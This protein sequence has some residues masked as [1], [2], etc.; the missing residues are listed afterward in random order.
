MNRE[1]IIGL[2]KHRIFGWIAKA[3]LVEK[4]NKEFFTVVENV[5]GKN[6][7]STINEYSET[8]Q[9]LIKITDQYTDSEITK[10]FSKKKQ[11]TRDFISKFSDEDLK[12][13][14]REY[15]EKRLIKLFDVLKDSNISLFFNS[16]S[17]NIYNEDK[18]AIQS[19]F[20]ETV[21]NFSKEEEES[22]YFLTVKHGQSEI[23]LYNKAGHIIT[24][25][26]CSILLENI[27]YF[28]K[29]EPEGIDGKKILP[30]LVKEHI[31]IPKKAEKKYFETFVLKSIE[32]YK[33][34]AIGFKI[35]ILP[36][37]PKPVLI[38]EKDWKD[39]FTMILKFDYNGNLVSPNYQKKRF[40]KFLIK[41]DKYIYEQ[42]DRD[43]SFEQEQSAFLQSIGLVN[44]GEN[45][46]K[47]HKDDENPV[48][49]TALIQWLNQF[50]SVLNEN[51]FDVQQKFFNK[52]Y[53]IEK[54]WID[55]KVDDHNDWFDIKA[56]VNFGGFNFP[57]MQLKNH[58]RNNNNEFVLPNGE[59]A[60]IPEEWFSKYR[61]FILFSEPK[62]NDFRLEK[63]HFQVLSNDIED[64]DQDL[65]K[66][67]NQINHQKFKIS[68][69]V[70]AKLR[71]YQKL[72]YDW[73]NSL[74][75]NK[76]GACLAD[77]MG[78]GKTLQTLAVI[79]RIIDLGSGKKES[80]VEKNK[81]KQ[82]S[83]FE[84]VLPEPK[85]VK[86]ESKK[87]GLIVMPTSLVHNWMNEIKKFT[88]DIKTYAYIGTRREK[89]T[90]NFS[91]F[92]VIL[93]SYG[94]VRNDIEILKK[95]QFNFLFLDESQAIKNPLS[96]TYKLIMEI[97]ANH[98]MVLTGTP[99]EN[100]LTDLWAQMNFVNPGLLGTL[101][102]FKEEFVDPIEKYQDA[103]LREEK[104]EKLQ[105]IIRP[106]FLRR[107]KEEVANDLPDLT[108]TIHYCSMSEE[109]HRIYEEEKSK[110]RN[111]L[112]NSFGKKKS[113]AEKNMLIIQALTKLRQLAN[114]TRL[115]DQKDENP[116][117][118]F[119]EVIRML[120]SLI[121]ENHKVLIFSSFVKHLNLFADYFKD[122][123]WKYSMLTGQTTKREEVINEFQ[124]DPENSLFLISLKAGGS[125]L[126]LTA[127]DYVF[128]L[129]PWWNPASEKQAIARAHRIGQ[130]KKVMAYRFI[131]E[132]SIEEKILKFQEK[133]QELADVF[134]NNNNPFAKLSQNEI[135]DIFD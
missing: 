115:I 11:S 116:S 33:V 85:V 54:A 6:L 4:Q 86:A 29:P 17:K 87:A 97:T 98:K 30:F 106:F 130:H 112:I 105:K 41:E 13:R 111:V 124:S 89:N 35:T 27:L 103:L 57:F 3:Y 78:L 63:H 49:D 93:T 80:I 69:K 36:T 58:I 131:T 95:Y 108:E 15:I 20:S 32:K 25:S 48:K 55:F 81:D 107:T 127:A 14:I 113:V 10:L 118:K 59:I 68:P 123:E 45:D 28:F 60:I 42:I 1:F 125:G 21:F 109:Q 135:M 31:I 67:M 34:N 39:E 19:G 16:D 9:K 129:D 50:G 96:K 91:N 120:E 62:G 99:I 52:K 56:T 71:P 133:K 23:N 110:I 61:D 18:I 119:D 75:E 47:I 114:H 53:F 8:Q 101:N 2:K 43:L 117:G 82:L 77:D 46:F 104:Q 88:P 12:I 128:I 74:Y 122:N 51:G 66:K 70:K 44:I 132:D 73:I 92:D 83:L 37:I 72:G 22:N 24:N 40:V 65:V 134:I 121:A 84:Q 7:G 100:T 64:I 79:R 38:V 76:F 5:S 102:F 90:D 26:P 126:N 94:I